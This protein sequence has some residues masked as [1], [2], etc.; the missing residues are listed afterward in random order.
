MEL[1]QNFDVKRSIKTLRFLNFDS[2]FWIFPT[3]GCLCR[4]GGC[5]NTMEECRTPA[6]RLHESPHPKN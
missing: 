5:S 1:F 3:E 6:F 2:G 4:M